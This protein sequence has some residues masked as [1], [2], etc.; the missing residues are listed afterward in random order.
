[1]AAGGFRIPGRV[2]QLSG[3]AE[4]NWEDG[5]NG[6]PSLP[7]SGHPV[8]VGVRAADDRRGCIMPVEEEVQGAVFGVWGGNGD[9]VAGILLT[10]TA[11]EGIG[12]E[13]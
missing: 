9:G 6:M 13:A 12:R 3:P 1:M 11:R 8:R 5:R 7:G 4:K 10:Y 2:V